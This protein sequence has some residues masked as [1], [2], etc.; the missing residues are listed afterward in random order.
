ME[1]ITWSALERLLKK[2]IEDLIANFSS[3]VSQVLNNNIIEYQVEE[4]NRNFYLKTLLHRAFPVKLLDVY[5]PLYL[6]DYPT[7]EK[8]TRIATNS[9]KDLFKRK[10]Y[11]TIIGSA[12]S[13]KSTLVKYLFL[14]AID[15]KF[16]IPIK[17]ELRYLNNF[18][19]DIFEYFE[20]KILKNQP[21]NKGLTEKLLKKGKFIIFFDGF[22]ELKSAIKPVVSKDLNEFVKKFNEN[23]FL[24]TSRPS[25][26][27]EFFPLFHNYS[28]CNLTRSEIKAFVKRQLFEK[29]KELVN[30]ITITIDKTDSS[31]FRSYLKNP[32]LLSM[33][34]LTFQSYS[35]LPQKRSLF[36]SQVFET[37]FSYH[38]SISKLSFVREK[39]SGLTK[40]QYTYPQFSNQRLS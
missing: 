26:N 14:K 5:Q 38:D 34:I 27:I 3:E 13:G 2:P 32:L 17:I 33:F 40:S 6:Q 8:R 21:L 4:Y 30:K 9:I 25:T 18:D 31:G 24:I 1:V 16:K 35:E 20:N 22:D 11:L 12:G 28:I 15:E 36:Y 29:E 23:A 39:Q 10:R 19:G 37:L 7:N